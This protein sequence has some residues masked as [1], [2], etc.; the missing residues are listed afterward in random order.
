MKA[1]ANSK[2]VKCKWKSSGTHIKLADDS[3]NERKGDRQIARVSLAVERLHEAIREAG[4]VS[5]HI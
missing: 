3:G 5:A 2:E 1:Q 4:T